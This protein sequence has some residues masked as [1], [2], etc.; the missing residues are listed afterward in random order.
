MND[1][2]PTKKITVEDFKTG[3]VRTFLTS[4]A[5]TLESEEGIQMVA[6]DKT[7]KG[8]GCEI[9]KPRVVCADENSP[10]FPGH[11]NLAELAVFLDGKELTGVFEA[12]EE[13]GYVDTYRAAYDKQ[14]RIVSL[15]ID[16]DEDFDSVPVADRYYGNVVIAFKN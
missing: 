6:S 9:K 1:N 10:H 13:E 3:E 15:F 14:G 11:E 8:C 12:N 5:V 2:T 4:G 16:K 7:C